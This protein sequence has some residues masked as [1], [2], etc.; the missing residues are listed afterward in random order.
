MINKYAGISCYGSFLVAA[1]LTYLPIE[2][3]FEI[4]L[5]TLVFLFLLHMIVYSFSVA[6]SA[7]RTYNKVLLVCFAVLFPA[8]SGFILYFFKGYRE[9]EVAPDTPNS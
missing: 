9:S 2:G 8:M 3:W 6:W 1:I 5:K 7:K 4:S